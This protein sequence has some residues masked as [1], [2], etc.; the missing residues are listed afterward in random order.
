MSALMRFMRTPIA[1][2]LALVVVLYSI[3]M[4]PFIMRNPCVKRGIWPSV[5]V[6]NPIDRSSW[7]FDHTGHWVFIP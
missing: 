3:G 5:S 6:I 2:G 4:P 7:C 1:M